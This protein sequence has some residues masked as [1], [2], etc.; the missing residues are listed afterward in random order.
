MVRRAGAVAGAG[1]GAGAATGA[2]RVVMAGAG[3]AG[4]A[5]GAGAVFAGLAGAA[6]APY[7][8]FTPLWP[9]QAPDLEAALVLVPSLHM[10]LAPAT[11]AA[12]GAAGALAAGLVVVVLAVVA[13]VEEVLAFVEVL[14][15]DLLFA[16]VGEPADTAVQVLVVGTLHT[17]S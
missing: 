16:R 6:V 11:G 17:I 2:G 4:A 1:A 13:L 12:E 10:P 14:V 9:R 5:A 7:H 3:A 15:D 8:S